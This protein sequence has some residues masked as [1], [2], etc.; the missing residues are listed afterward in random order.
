MVNRSGL[1]NVG[2]II[3]FPAGTEPR[4]L[5]RAT[6]TPVT[7]LTGHCRY[8]LPRTRQVI[9][10]PQIRYFRLLPQLP[11]LQQHLM[12]FLFTAVLSITTCSIL[13]RAI[14]WCL[15]ALIKMR[16]HEGKHR[17]VA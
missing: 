11:L 17:K 1:L 10:L 15:Q 5:D 8:V 2:E 3:A 7:A 6:C 12:S 13:C 14:V 9:L 4:F 16:G